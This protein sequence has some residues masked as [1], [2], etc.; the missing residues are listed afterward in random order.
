MN[1]FI[2]FITENKIMVAIAV[3]ALAVAIGAGYLLGTRSVP[4]SAATAN[5]TETRKVLFY[6]SPMSPSVT[7]PVPTKDAMGMDYIPVYEE[8]KKKSAEH[9]ILFYRNPMNPSVTSPVPAKDSMGMDYVPV[10]AQ[11][12]GGQ[13]ENAGTVT[14]DPVTVQN[15]GV[16]TAIAEKRTLSRSVR[17]VGRVEFDET[18]LTRLHPKISGWV[19]KL[20]VA[21]TGQY[22]KK[23]A[24]LL[25]IYSPQLVTSQQEYI[26]ALKNRETLANSPFEDVRIG[27]ED[28][29]KGT[30]ERLQLL[31]VPPHQIRQL[32]K[33]RKVKKTLHIHSPF[34]GVVIKMG[35]REGQHVSPKTQLYVLADLSRVWVYADIYEHELPWIKLGDKANMQLTSVPGKTFEGQVTYIYPY[36]ETKTRT[37]KVRLEFAN[38]RGLLKPNMFA[39]VTINASRQVNA[40][41]IPSEAV[42]R[43]GTR[44]Q[45]FVVRGPGKFEPREVRLGI[46]SNG[47]TQV[48]QG[49]AV[50]DQVVTSAQFLID[51]ESKLREATSKMMEAAKSKNS[52]Q[53]S[54]E[55]SSPPEPGPVD[56]KDGNKHEQHGS[57]TVAPG[58]ETGKEQKHGGMKHD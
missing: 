36:A 50:G 57:E 9:K 7:S 22:V 2:E 32:E 4:E 54:G 38:P 11:E 58:S 45:V 55:K 31:D 6:R 12:S 51:S 47:Y 34:S 28:L 8:A 40:I 1:K 35:A 41:V 27:A 39:D 10:Y 18:R 56:K 52:S 20:Y 3:I 37:V 21:K 23:D 5:D 29:L 44:E 25:G 49:V 33:T 26:L 46:T 16:R 30:R 13:A 42:V 14:I 48:L 17:T 43:S 19:E 15:I 24:V 53:Q